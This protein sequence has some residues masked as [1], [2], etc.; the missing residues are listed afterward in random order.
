MSE[1]LVDR[2]VREDRTA[3][4][5]SIKPIEVE[6]NVDQ[7]LAIY[8]EHRQKHR[9]LNWPTVDMRSA[10]EGWV[11]G[12]VEYELRKLTGQSNDPSRTA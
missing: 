9:D 8:Y 2:L 1:S 6:L 12:L 5:I 7:I 11:R 10:V 4:E 3:I